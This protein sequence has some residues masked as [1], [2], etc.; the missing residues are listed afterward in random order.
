MEDYLDVA[1][2]IFEGTK[3]KASDED[4]RRLADNMILLSRR[5]LDRLNKRLTDSKGN[6]V[7]PTIAE[8]NLAAML[9]SKLPSEISIRYEPDEVQPPPD[10]KIEV[11]GIVYW[12][13]MKDLSKLARENIQRKTM[14][15][16]QKEA[17]QIKIGRFFS[18]R[19]SDDF[20]ED[21]VAELIKFMSDKATSAAEQKTLLY[22]GKRGEQAEVEFWSPKKLILSELTLG[23]AGDLE[24]LDL[25]ALA[26]DQIKGSLRK[27][28]RAFNWDSGQRN[29]N[30]IVMEADGKEDID[31][32]DAVFGTE[33]EILGGGRH[34][35]SRNS[36]GLFDDP[37]FLSK[38]AGVIA[39]K[40]KI[41]W[42]EEIALLSAEE[43]VGRLSP[44]EREMTKGMNSEDI[45]KALEWK[46]PG[47][48]AEYS[49]ILYVN[50][51]FEYPLQNI[52]M[53]F[54]FDRIVHYNMRPD[55]GN[56]DFE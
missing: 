32:C 39:V 28:V 8:H 7:W 16:V 41:E 26:R 11:G 35:W 34:S 9:A 23:S 42:V 15:R 13:Q 19:L 53:L 6:G 1:K 54:D 14:D 44:K 56:G 27:A 17:M 18:C 3:Y 31:I 45:K 5:G 36:D 48:V 21:S 29:M 55:A 37:A 51:R 52:E 33:Y 30:L 40:R 24:V 22:T 43:V 46:D 12:I 49:Q 47:P 50:E 2:R 20:R 38:V 4:I 10:F 25:T